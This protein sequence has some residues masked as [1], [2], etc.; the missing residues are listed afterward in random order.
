MNEG[1]SC[2]ENSNKC[3]L[4]N[5]VYDE[6]ENLYKMDETRNRRFDKQVYWILIGIV[7]IFILLLIFTLIFIFF[8]VLKNSWFSTINQNMTTKSMP[9]FD[10]KFVWPKT[11]K[12]IDCEK[13]LKNDSIYLKDLNR[14]TYDDSNDLDMSCEGIRKRN[15]FPENPMS[16]EEADFPLAYA[17]IV[18]K[19]KF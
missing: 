10:L 5:A 17:K 8:F 4:A 1:D 6:N 19:V 9:N 14:E 11:V 3:L 2:I 7:L 16:Q 18:Y 13:V 15:Y 12:F